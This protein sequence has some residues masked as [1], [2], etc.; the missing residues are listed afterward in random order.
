MSQSKAL[1]PTGVLAPP[2]RASTTN[3]N[4]EPPVRTKIGVPSSAVPLEA[5]SVSSARVN[6]KNVMTGSG[7]IV[8][9][10]LSV[11]VGVAVID[12]VIVIVG[13]K[14]MVRVAVGVRVNE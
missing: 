2:G 4:P 8:G 12:G 9:V 11:M 3:E 1:P 14:V 5:T 6:P 10:G 13:V 7:G